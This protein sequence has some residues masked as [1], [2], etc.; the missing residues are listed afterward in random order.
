[1]D[2]TTPAQEK[3]ACINQAITEGFTVYITGGYSTVRWTPATVAKFRKAGREPFT[4]TGNSLYMAQGRGRVCITPN[5]IC[6]G[7]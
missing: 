7:K 3:L 5:G 2:Y 6:F 4:V 1:M